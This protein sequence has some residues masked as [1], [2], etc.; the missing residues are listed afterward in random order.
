[1]TGPH[2]SSAGKTALVTGGHRDRTGHRGCA[3][4]RWAR[5]TVN[6]NHAPDAAANPVAAIEAAGGTALAIAADVRSRSEYQVHGAPDAS[7]TRALGRAGEQRRGRD[8]QA[9]R[10][11]HRGGLRPQ[12]RWNV[13]G[14]FQAGWITAQNIRVSGGTP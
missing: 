1:M 14:V 3:G 10:P 8:H 6:H 4:R 5:V 7:G 9:I 2:A 12:F 11:D 13:K